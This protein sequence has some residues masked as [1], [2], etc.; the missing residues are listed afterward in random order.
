V[1]TASA[2]AVPLTHFLSNSTGGFDAFLYPET[3]TGTPSLQS[4]IFTL[5]QA[6]NPGYVIILASPTSLFNNTSSWVDVIHFFKIGNGPVT[7]IQ[8]LVGG[9]N[10]ASYFPSLATVKNS[11]FTT[12]VK[13]QQLGS[14]FTID[15]LTGFTNFT[16]YSVRSNVTRNYHFFTGILSVPDSGSTFILLSAALGALIIFRPRRQRV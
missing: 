2:Q 12:I 15:P 4:G 13:G 5:P 14:V 16:D 6:V 10:Q 7:N 11:P 3:L 8:M 9:P 1:L